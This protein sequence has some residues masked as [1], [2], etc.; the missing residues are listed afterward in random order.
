[1]SLEESPNADMNCLPSTS[2]DQW[3]N[4]FNTNVFGTLN[5]TRAFLPHMRSSKAGIVVFIG[6]MVAWDGLPAGGAYCAS[7]AAIHCKSSFDF[8]SCTGRNIDS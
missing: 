4:Q 7:K 6:S 2:H 1:M 3:F 8:F 5:T